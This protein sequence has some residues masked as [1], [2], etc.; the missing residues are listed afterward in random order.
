MPD[1]RRFLPSIRSM[2]PGLSTGTI[3]LDNAGGSQLPRCVIDAM[4][5]YME[6]SFVQLHGDY[7]LS[8]CATAVIPRARE[9]VKVFLGGHESPGDRGDARQ[10]RPSPTPSLGEG[11]SRPAGAAVGAGLGEVF[12]G[13]S[14]TVLCYELA[15]A[16]AD[17]RDAC[18]NLDA[19]PADL[20]EH[21]AKAVGTTS[22]SVL[23]G[24]HGSLRDRLLT[25]DQ[26]VVCT[27]GHEANVGPWMR[28]ALRGYTIVPWHVEPTRDGGG[29]T[30][31][32]PSLDTLKKLVNS[33]TLLV[34][35]PQV[36]N[37]L[38]EVWE[39]RGAAEIAHG[40]GARIVVDGVAYAP[41]RAPR[42]SELGCDWYVYSTYKVFGP[43][44]AAMFGTHE[45]MGELVGPNHYFLDS[46][47]PYKWELGNASHEAAAGIAAL[48]DFV[49][50]LASLDGFPSA[51]G[52]RSGQGVGSMDVV[53]RGD[54]GQ[55]S[56][57]RNPPPTPSLGEGGF[58][59]RDWSTPPTRDVFDRAFAIVRDLEDRHTAQLID[60]L[61]SK[62]SVR[63]VGPRHAE[64]SRVGT[65]SFT[66][67]KST[68]VQ[69]S[70]HLG[71]RNV[72]MRQGHAYSKRLVEQLATDRDLHID[73]ALGVARL[74]IQHY[75]SPEEIGVV[76]RALDEI[77]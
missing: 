46:K 69:I 29:G 68:P 30:N 59:Q 32:R 2:F 8:K 56:A 66:S 75:N 6:K 58:G 43:H 67:T 54:R 52:G 24:A 65:I 10:G 13:S 50:Q 64:S 39:V 34:L 77:L 44:M 26:I 40:A 21:F 61:K 1:A 49:C 74:S 45:A 37:I 41:H 17:A 4:R 20:R 18:R 60:Y 51:V 70:H 12:F 27:A 53:H 73:P 76:C 3:M 33:R 47:V 23:G 57:T 5:E 38:G 63:I 22:G 9:V 72:A 11:A 14:S 36:S 42:M 16:Y 31:W 7:P 71:A 28:L 15:A 48:W 25:R 62:P 55:A 19:A 35:M